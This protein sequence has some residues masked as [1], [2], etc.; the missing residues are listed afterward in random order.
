MNPQTTN[1]ITILT[2][3]ILA[4]GGVLKEYFPNLLETALL[5]QICFF[6]SWRLKIVATCLFLNFL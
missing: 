1:A 2:H 4:I 5:H 3:I 6:F